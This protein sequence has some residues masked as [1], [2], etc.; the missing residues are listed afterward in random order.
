MKKLSIPISPPV[1]GLAL[2][3]SLGVEGAVDV[4]LHA[5]RLL[6]EVKRA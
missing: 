6:T 2:P 5:A 3:A 4:A 1:R